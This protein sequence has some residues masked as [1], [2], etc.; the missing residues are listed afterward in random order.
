M[1]STGSDG[2]IRG[3]KNMKVTP[4]QMVSAHV[5]RRFKKYVLNFTKPPTFFC[6]IFRIPE[7]VIQEWKGDAPAHLPPQVYVLLISLL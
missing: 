6:K 7:S 5:P 3:T 1:D 4:I 2:N